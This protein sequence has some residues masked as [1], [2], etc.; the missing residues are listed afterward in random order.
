LRKCCITNNL[1]Q[2]LPKS[3][4]SSS[5]S[6]MGLALSTKGGGAVVPDEVDTVVET[7][8]GDGGRPRPPSLS[9]SPSSGPDNSSEL[10]S[11]V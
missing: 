9:T 3:K 2:K 6:L 5:S 4:S 1:F 10:T 7:G 8:P 11:D